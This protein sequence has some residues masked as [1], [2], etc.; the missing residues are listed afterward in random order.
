M[1]K[2][3]ARIFLEP[4]TKVFRKFFDPRFFRL[5]SGITLNYAK[6]DAVNHAASVR[7]LAIRDGLTLTNTRVTHSK[8]NSL[9]SRA[10]CKTRRRSSTTSSPTSG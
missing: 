1:L 7:D 6:L 8:A 5:E 2:R 10:T 4:F 9:H 3:I